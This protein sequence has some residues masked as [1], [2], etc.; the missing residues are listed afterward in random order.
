V[1]VRKLPAETTGAPKTSETLKTK[2]TPKTIKTTK[3]PET[4][5]AEKLS[6]H[7]IIRRCHFTRLEVVNVQLFEFLLEIIR[8]YHPQ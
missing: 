7:S 1:S 5:T 4:S 8:L 3:A 6:L 2:E